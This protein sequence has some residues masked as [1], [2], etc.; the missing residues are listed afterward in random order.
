MCVR[1]EIKLMFWCLL[2][3]VIGIKVSI[4]INIWLPS[5]LDCSIQF[6]SIMTSPIEPSGRSTSEVDLSTSE[7]ILMMFSLSKSI[8]RSWKVFSNSVNFTFVRLSGGLYLLFQFNT[9]WHT[10]NAICCFSAKELV[11]RTCLFTKWIFCCFMNCDS[12]QSARCHHL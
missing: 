12:L 10:T 3:L 1:Y 4:I 8:W 7:S 11:T 5:F 6:C 2:Y 9:L